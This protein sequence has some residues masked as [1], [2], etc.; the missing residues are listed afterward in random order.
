MQ[1]RSTSAMPFVQGGLP[2]PST[3][4]SASVSALAVDEGAGSAGAALVR[5][6][7]LGGSPIVTEALAEGGDTAAEV[8]TPADA[9]R[10]AQPG[11]AASATSA[12][13]GRRARREVKRAEGGRIEAGIG[14]RNAPR[15]GHLPIPPPAAER[16]HFTS[17]S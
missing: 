1:N 5:A 3:P 2:S 17:T 15:R 8:G 16:T 9:A 13:S 4:A 14:R 7:G 6:G 11:S 12:A 10:S